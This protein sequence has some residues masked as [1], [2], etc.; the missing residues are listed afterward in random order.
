MEDA[1]RFNIVDAS[2]RTLCAA[3]GFPGAFVGACYD[4]KGGVIGTGICPCCLWE[5][6]FDDDANAGASA[7]PAIL[8]SLRRY[9]LGWG[10]AGPAW[11][12]RHNAMPEGWNG[13]DQL[14]RLYEAAPFL[15]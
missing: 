4:E 8:D 1:R 6:G 10:P 3:C 2:G 9:R 7:Q 12:G 15:K 11:S 5:P 13:K 14:E